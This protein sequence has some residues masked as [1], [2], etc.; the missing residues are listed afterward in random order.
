MD[1]DL[2]RVLRRLEDA[3][4]F[5]ESYRFELTEEYLSLIDTVEA[6]PRNQSGADKSGRWLG[7][8]A[9]A[10]SLIAKATP[11]NPER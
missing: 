5:A 8:R 4:T 11:L 1:A 7:S 2:Q 6:M 10:R 9:F 3:A